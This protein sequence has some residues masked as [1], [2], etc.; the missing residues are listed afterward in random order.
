MAKASSGMAEEI[1]VKHFS[2][3]WGIPGFFKKLQNLS[4][5]F[6]PLFTFKR[7]G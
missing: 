1:A 4:P 7:W 5:D 3:S 6:F 2:L